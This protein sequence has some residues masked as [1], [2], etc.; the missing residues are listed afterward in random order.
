MKKLL[1]ISFTILFLSACGSI[2]SFEKELIEVDYTGEMEVFTKGMSYNEVLFHIDN[3][4]YGAMSAYAHN[5]DGNQNIKL[6]AD[7]G[8]SG[9]WSA[10]GSIYTWEGNTRLTLIY[11]YLK[12]GYDIY[13]NYVNID[14]NNQISVGISNTIMSLD[15]PIIA[16]IDGVY[17]ESQTNYERPYLE[18][19]SSVSSI[20]FDLTG[21]QNNEIITEVGFRSLDGGKIFI[22]S[23]DIELESMEISKSS[24]VLTNEISATVIEHDYTSPTIIFSFLPFSTMDDYML[25]IKTAI[26]DNE[27][28]FNYILNGYSFERGYTYWL[29]DEGYPLHLDYDFE[30]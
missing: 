3:L 2:N 22:V 7:L 12:Y 14:L 24:R 1:L 19:K 13:N 4:D 8:A 28:E 29:N 9:T 26:G 25:Y 30:Y 6:S 18:F 20:A 17:A 10:S 27:Y 23:A 5:K 16:T 15:P 21:L 11:P